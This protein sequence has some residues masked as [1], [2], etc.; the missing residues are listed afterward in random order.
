MDEIQMNDQQVDTYKITADLQE[1]QNHLCIANH[2]YATCYGVTYQK[3][4]QFSGSA[5]EEA[6]IRHNITVEMEKSLIASFNTESIENVIA[7][8]THQEFVLMKAVGIRG[9]KGEIIGVFVLTGVAKELLYET[10]QIPRGIRLTTEED[11]DHA[12]ALIEQ[13]SKHF[14]FF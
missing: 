9:S 8:E 3:L 10:D 2:V 11:F 4:T 14:F 12:T 7:G 13:L 5:D 1:M 6:F